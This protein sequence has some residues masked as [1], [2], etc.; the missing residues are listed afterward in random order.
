MAILILGGVV[1][2]DLA[3]LH[4]HDEL[5]AWVP[6]LCALM[7]MHPVGEMHIQPYGHWEGGA[8]SVVQFLEESALVIHTYPERAY[9]EFN[10][11]SCKAIPGEG[12]DGGRVTDAIVDALG[13]DL[14]YRRYLGDCNW[15]ELSG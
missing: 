11:H 12:D 8:P 4:D 10:L 15:R 3:I 13:L 2:R 14:R 1:Q 7:D 6:K 9:I 5:R